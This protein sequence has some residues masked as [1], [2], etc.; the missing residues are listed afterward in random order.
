MSTKVSNKF[1]ITLVDSKYFLMEVFDNVELEVED[2]IIL[3]EFQ[4]ELGGGK[5]FPVIILPSPTATTN[6]DLIKHISKK[7]SLPYTKA[8][9]F[10]LT[11][12]PQKILAKLYIR[13]VPPERPTQFFTKK[14]EAIKWI[15]KFMD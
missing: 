2:V 6:S 9:A 14:E 15:E 5:Q 8:D 1:K 13:F 12:V 3:V 7:D 4:K 10:I 11:S